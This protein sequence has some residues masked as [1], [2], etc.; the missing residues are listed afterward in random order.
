M[1][2]PAP[3][4]FTCTLHINILKVLDAAQHL[5]RFKCW[6]QLLAVA[7]LPLG[8]LLG[9]VGARQRSAVSVGALNAVG[10]GALVCALSVQVYA[11]LLQV[12]PLPCDP[13]L[14]IAPP[15]LVILRPPL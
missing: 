4:K 5:E 10:A 8:A 2:S 6:V 15:S 9:G 3:W 1:N 12:P 7:V 13:S 14:V 11:Q